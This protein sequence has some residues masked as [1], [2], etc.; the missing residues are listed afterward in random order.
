MDEEK[1]VEKS[2]T[3]RIGPKMKELKEQTQDRIYKKLS[4]QVGDIDVM[5]MFAERIMKVGGVVV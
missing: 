2:W 3:V 1:E 5:E 4:L